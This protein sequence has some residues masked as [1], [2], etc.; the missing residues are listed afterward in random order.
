M[1]SISDVMEDRMRKMRA[2]REQEYFECVNYV[3]EHD[4]KPTHGPYGSNMG[5]GVQGYVIKGRSGVV[6][7]KDEDVEKA[8]EQAQM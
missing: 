7:L 2:K 3:A 6:F 1:L 5:M 8:R 4:L